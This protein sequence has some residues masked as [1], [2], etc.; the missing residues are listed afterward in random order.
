[1]ETEKKTT[2]KLRARI[3]YLLTTMGNKNMSTLGVIRILS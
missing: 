1:M 2:Q 3:N